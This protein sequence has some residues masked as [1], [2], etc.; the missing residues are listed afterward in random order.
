MAAKEWLKDLLPRYKMVE[1]NTSI[2]SGWYLKLVSAIKDKEK[3]KE[4]CTSQ[5]SFI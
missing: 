4:L 2:F 1:T 3:L 5:E